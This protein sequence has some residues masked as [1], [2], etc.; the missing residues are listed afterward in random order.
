MQFAGHLPENPPGCGHRRTASCSTSQRRKPQEG[1]WGGSRP[2]PFP[3]EL[4]TAWP[5][6]AAHVGAGFPSI[7]DHSC[8][9]VSACPPG[10]GPFSYSRLLV[11][12]AGCQLIPRTSLYPRGPHCIILAS[13]QVVGER[14]IL[15]VSDSC[16]RAHLL[17]QWDTGAVHLPPGCSHCPVF[18]PEQK[19]H[20][21]ELP[22]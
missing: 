22:L 19:E 12:M 18:M 2:W 13:A 21:L 6:R 10:S 5:S 7:S 17:R 14:S 9:S 20:C 8:L 15:V 11:W 3:S 1:L 4:P 16:S